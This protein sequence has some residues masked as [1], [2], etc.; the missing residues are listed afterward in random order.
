MNRYKEIHT[1]KLT[2][3]AWAHKL[4]IK[5]I[6]YDGFESMEYFNNVAIPVDDFLNR[7]ACSTVEKPINTSRREA[8]KVLRQI[9]NK[10]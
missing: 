5:F 7:A 8:S 9:N 1:N 2:S 10:I 6:D 4:N 3:R